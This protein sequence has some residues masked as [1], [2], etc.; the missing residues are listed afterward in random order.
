MLL[1]HHLNE[2]KAGFGGIMDIPAI[3]ASIN[4][5]ITIQDCMEKKQDFISKITRVQT[6]EHLPALQMQSPESSP[7]PP[8]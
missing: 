2:K 8:K 6:V 1:R 5:R 4:R 7:V 3:A